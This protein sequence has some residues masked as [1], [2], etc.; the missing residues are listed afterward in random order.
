M[1]EKISI[2]DIASRVGTSTTTVSFVL[3]G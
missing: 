3:N 1:H 2:K